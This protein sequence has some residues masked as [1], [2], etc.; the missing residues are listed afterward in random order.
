MSPEQIG[1]MNK[2]I[3]YS[4]DFYSLGV[5]FYKILTGQLPFQVDEPIQWVHAHMAQKPVSPKEINPDI[6]PVVSAIIM[7]LLAKTAEER[8]QSAAGLLEDLKECR[9]QWSQTGVIVPFTLGRVGLTGLFQLPCMLYGREKEMEVLTDAYECLCSGRAGLLLVQG[10]AGTGKTALIHETLRPLAAERGYFT[11]GKYDQLQ[12][13]IPFAPFTK[14][15]GGLMH[16]F[17][18]ES[19]ESLIAWKKRLSLA[20]GR[21]GA[22][23]SE[24]IPEV[25]LIVGPQPPLETLP[26]RE[27]QNRFRMVFRN[28]IRALAKKEHPLALFL[29]DLQWADQAS[30]E[31]L[32]YLC[33]DTENHYLLF[34]GA[35]RDNEVTSTH[36]LLSIC[37][38]L[39]KT[40]ILV[41]H[42]TLT[43]LDPIHTCQLV[44][45]TLH[46]DKAKSKQLAEILHRKTSGNPFFL[47]QLIMEAYECNLLR[48]SARDGCLEWDPASIQEMPMTDD[49]INLLLGKLKK[50]PD[51]T[52]KVL[53]LAACIGN[54]FDLKTLAIA[55]EK[56]R[57]Q[58][59][60]DLC[61]SIAEG[62]ALPVNDRDN[63]AYR[64]EFSHDRVQQ[65]AY[66]LV[67]EDEKKKVH[68][69]IGRL[70]LKNTV[71]D[72]LIIN[73]FNIMDHLNRGL[74]LIENSS[75][76]IKLAGYN[77]LAGIKSKTST[78]YGSALNY[79]KFGLELLTDQGWNEHYRLTFNLHLELSQC[80]YLCGRYDI[81]EQLFESLLARTKTDLER[82]DIYSIKMTLYSGIERYHEALQLGIKG[83][84]LL[85][86]NLPERPGKFAFIKEIFLA[87]WHLRSL[88]IDDFSYL[89][90]MSDQVQIKIMR[91]LIVQA[92]AACILNPELFA[93]I[94]LRIFSLSIKYGNN[95]YSAIGFG[96]YSFVIGSIMGDYRTGHKFEQLALKLIEEYDNRYCKCIFYFIIGTFVSH[97]AEHGKT[98]I[99]HLQKAVDNGLEAGELLF[100]GFAMAILIEIKFLLGV[101]LKDL[102]QEC[103]SYY[104]STKR[105]I[106]NYQL[107]IAN[108]RGLAGDLNTL[109]SEENSDEGM[110]PINEDDLRELIKGDN[111]A[112]MTYH[113]SKLQLN[114]LYG[115]YKSALAIAE[116]AQ[117]NLYDVSG[118]MLFAEYIFYYS[119]VIT[120]VYDRLS[121]E[122][123][124]KYW[125]IIKKHQRNFKKWSNSC[126][127]NF[128]HKYLLVAAELARLVGKDSEAMT[129]YDRAIQFAHEN[130]FCQNEAI[131]SEL[132]ARFYLAKGRDKVAQVYLTDACHGY[133]KWGAVRKV[134]TLQDQYPHLLAGIFTIE[135]EALEP[136]ELFKTP[137]QFVN[138]G[139]SNSTD[140]LDLY[141][142]RKALQRLSK[143]T[144]PEKM[145]K[146]FLDIV[147]EYAGADK[148]YLIL[149]KNEELFIETAKDTEIHTVTVV[150]PVHLEKCTKLSKSMVRYVVRT[151][152]PVVVNDMDQA[153]IFARDRYL[154]QSR[155]KSI[156]CLSL[157]CQGIPMGV[158][159][160][161]NSLITGVFTPERVEM[162]KLL[163]SQIAYVQ[164][165]QSFLEEDTPRRKSEVLKP[166]I[167]PL[168]ERELDVLN[169][170]AVG[171]SNEEIAKE[172]RLA[173]STVKTHIINIY[174]KLQVN[175]RVQAVGRARELRLLKKE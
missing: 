93:L 27:T 116:K 162:L 144:V 60:A 32:H 101:P 47:K 20:L 18:T 14:A 120:A 35:Y 149:E 134:R 3:D 9:R 74:D 106:L 156:V 164:K 4:S 2:T 142:I 110:P 36:P 82:A 123:K 99:K 11:T 49:V 150:T 10:Y 175:R 45:D 165:L 69:K 104:G 67:P 139:D 138:V 135:K 161:E 168:T 37:A 34:I 31:L 111:K 130:G 33:E 89:P 151:L 44:A 6:P 148:G 1:R 166:L 95:E 16:Q 136:S 54:T 50:L 64:Y 22:V 115:D 91:L 170:I 140:E 29:D 75:E 78:A 105:A 107:L 96:S 12:Q 62:F 137:Y 112:F 73:I 114:Y 79:F 87:K 13:N 97:W 17:L 84:I 132:A 21:N 26:L 160:L 43:S 157:L 171:M 39:Q 53:S 90:E 152:E 125:K 153:G 113:F 124:S 86:V 169:L 48:L 80:E 163:S 41:Q 98:S 66:F 92:S 117:Q 19:R 72:E 68:L 30:L 167:E 57:A 129:L 77:L 70:I 131:A 85:G 155:T 147:I 51:K 46:C 25:E 109:G 141:T 126:P 61:P 103:Q 71:Q 65:A 172:L 55:S 118:Y 8:Y 102:A 122:Q 83:L 28:F 146:S 174:G 159:Y 42:L 63:L 119:L 143:E 7:K 76:R 52:R 24:V 108:L 121:A 173:K 133:H 100:T 158:L 88:K 5:V 128:Q 56:T 38:E 23:N 127:A 81:A 40:G 145:L 15:L 94:M 58:T 154:A 59:A